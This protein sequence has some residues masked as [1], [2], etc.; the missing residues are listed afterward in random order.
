MTITYNPV[1][2]IGYREGLI[3]TTQGESPRREHTE[4]S[5]NDW[6]YI[7]W[8]RYSVH[9]YRSDLSGWPVRWSERCG[10]EHISD[11]ELNSALETELT[12]HMTILRASQELEMD[13][14]L[15]HK[16][17]VPNIEQDELGNVTIYGMETNG[18]LWYVILD[19]NVI[20]KIKEL[21]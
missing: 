4:R 15:E 21:K 3:V 8:T 12:A 7:D 18:K 17:E 6:F 1:P 19:K 13:V 2:V 11:E 14:D 9:P 10:V 20:D 16:T 5:S